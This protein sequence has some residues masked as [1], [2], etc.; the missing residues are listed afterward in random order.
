[1]K[2]WGEYKAAER[3]KRTEVGLKR[4]EL[5]A[6]PLDWPAIKRYVGRLMKRRVA[7]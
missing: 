4:L 7:K 6:H 2:K 1:V 5:W 3:A